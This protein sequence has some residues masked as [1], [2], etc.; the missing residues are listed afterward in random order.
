MTVTF[1]EIENAGDC[2]G[3]CW[4]KVSRWGVC[5]RRINM[6][7]EKVH[8]LKILHSLKINL[9]HL[10]TKILSIQASNSNIFLL[11]KFDNLNVTNYHRRNDICH[12]EIYSFQS[13]RL[14]VQTSINKETHRQT[15]YKFLRNATRN[16]LTLNTSCGFIGWPRTKSS[17]SS[18]VSAL[19]AASENSLVTGAADTAVPPQARTRAIKMNLDVNCIV[20]VQM[21]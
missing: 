11:W 16:G 12:D 19:R 2:E 18:A 20:I 1:L 15:K 21:R 9:S 4:G 8:Y 5:Q 7:D 3:H 10:I 17:M 6:I 13:R 14:W